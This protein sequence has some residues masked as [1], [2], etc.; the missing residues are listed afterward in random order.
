MS[1]AGIASNQ[2]VSCNNLQDAVNNGIFTLKNTIPVSAKQITKAE[3]NNYVN[4]NSAYAPYAAKVYN[5]LVVKSNLQPCATLPYSYTLY[6]DYYDGN[7]LAGVSTSSAA[8]ALTTAFTVYSSSSSI[9]VGTT[10]YADSC[11]NEQIYAN[12][13]GSSLPYYKID[14]NYITF[15]DWDATGYG[16]QIRTITDCG[17]GLAMIQ[18]ATNQSL[19]INLYLSTITVNGVAVVNIGGTDPNVPGNGGSVETSQIGTYNVSM[20]F[21]SSVP[22]QHIELVDSAFNYFCN[23]ISP[24]YSS[25]TFYGVVI[26]TSTNPYITCADGTC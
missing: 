1:W 17:G 6:C 18:I 10:L 25:T 8:C 3:A 26:N 23:T 24:G 15:E 22:G 5:Q 4:L 21:S 11:G 12:A 9:G 7:Y 2:C 13:Y 14:G 16:Y 20:D 19:D